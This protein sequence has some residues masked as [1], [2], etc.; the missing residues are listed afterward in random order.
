[1]KNDYLCI[2]KCIFYFLEVLYCFYISINIQAQSVP[3]KIL[4]EKEVNNIRPI[5]LNEIGN[6]ISYIPLE[7]SENCFLKDLIKV[8]ATE[9]HIAVWDWDRV[10]LFDLSGR[11]ITEIGKKGEGP[12]E[13]I[14]LN[15]Y[16]FSW[17]GTKIYLLTA[18]STRCLE[19]DLQ[20]NFLQS[21]KINDKYAKML[22]LNENLFVFHPPSQQEGRSPTQYNL[23]ISDFQNNIRNSYKNSYILKASS[24][25]VMFGGS[26]AFYSYQRNIRF[27]EHGADTLFTVTENEL[28]PYSVFL[29]GNR[30]M[31]LDIAVPASAYRS[32]GTIDLERALQ[33]YAG[34]FFVES[35]REATENIYFSLNDWRQSLFGYYNKRNN[36]VKILGKD[37]FQNNIDGG[38]PFWPK[39]ISNN[40][41]L[42]DFEN[43]YKLREHVLTGTAAELRVKFGKKYDDLVKLV[44]SLDDESNP[45]LIMVKK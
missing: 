29:L 19:Y 8:V 17:D 11:F 26:G 9:S 13:Y 40:D 7:T 18:Y 22:P 44:N 20:G 34:K 15:D 21:Y 33:A 38:L 36:I 4:L 35:V 37:G 24:K 45:V 25:F 41:I 28:I 6:D 23:V 32:D 3:Y 31:P 42:F 2:K 10:L 12:G 16:C 5:N 27:K 30:L 14:Q 39:Y 1:M 43:A